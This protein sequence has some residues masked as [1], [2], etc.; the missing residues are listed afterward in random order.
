MRMRMWNSTFVE[1]LCL[2]SKQSHLI[3]IEFHTIDIISYLIYAQFSVNRMKKMF[4]S[5]FRF[6]LYIHITLGGVFHCPCHCF[7]CCPLYWDTTLTKNNK[8]DLSNGEINGYFN[9]FRLIA[10]ICLDIEF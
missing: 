1:E 3:D 5:E 7:N 4:H 2:E 8:T 9:K 10:E 6:T